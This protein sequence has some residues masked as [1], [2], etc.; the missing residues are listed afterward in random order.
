MALAW[1]LLISGLVISSVAI[2]Y[3]VTGLAAIFSAAVIPIIIMGGSLEV[4]KIV[5]ALWLHKYWKKAPFLMKSYLVIAVFVLMLITSLGIF[6]F[7]SK[8]HNDQILVTGD[9]DSQIALYDEQINIERENIENSRKL[10]KQLDDVVIKKTEQEGREYKDKNNNTVKE[11]VAERALQIRRSQSKDRAKLTKDIELAQTKIIEIQQKKAPI[12]SEARKVQAEVGP[13]KYVAK[14]IYGEADQNLLEKAV[15]WMILTIIFVFDP[16]AILLLLASQWTF[17]WL[18]NQNNPPSIE[19][20]DLNNNN[21]KTPTSGR[22]LSDIK[23]KNNEK[24]STN[25]SEESLP[26]AVD[27][28]AEVMSQHKPIV[29]DGEVYDEEGGDLEPP[30]LPAEE[31]E[32]EPLTEKELDK[33]KELAD[34]NEDDLKNVSTLFPEETWQ[35]EIIDEATKEK[36]NTILGEAETIEPKDPLEDWNLMIEQAEKAVEEEKAQKKMA[37]YM[38]KENNEQIKKVR[39]E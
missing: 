2:F 28:A 23:P 34:V 16:L 33:I 38:T 27:D 37:S 22:K 15:T 12:A 31:N 11:D 17:G 26:S 8:A 13:I 6:G 7:L 32:I 21:P 35:K 10:I 4:G 14:F 29:I 9:I 30:I 19:K 24:V 20:K 1:L 18:K 25:K 39:E 5:T 36:P 3:S